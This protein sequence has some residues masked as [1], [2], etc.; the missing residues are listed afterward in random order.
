MAMPKPEIIQGEEFI[1]RSLVGKLV[2]LALEE[3]D[4]AGEKAD[5]EQVLERRDYWPRETI[6]ELFGAALSQLFGKIPYLSSDQRDAVQAELHA[7]TA[8]AQEAHDLRKFFLDFLEKLH[9]N[10][11]Q[12]GLKRIPADVSKT[13]DDQ[14]FLMIIIKKVLAD[15]MGIEKLSIGKE[16]E[17]ERIIAQCIREIQKP[18]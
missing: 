3:Y 11:F 6:I 12:F 9:G 10:N 8:D 7:F 1:P 13:F 18:E 2:Q 4:D 15:V 14:A 17:A 16:S 5:I